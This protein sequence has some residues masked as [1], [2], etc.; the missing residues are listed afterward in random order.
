M[1][2]DGRKRC[3][4]AGAKNLSDWQNRRSEVARERTALAQ[5]FRAELLRQL[6]PQINATTRALAESAVTSYVA[7][8]ITQSRFTQGRVN[9]DAMDILLRTQSQL[10]RTLKLLG[11][12]FPVHTHD[13]SDAPPPGAT[14][15]ERRAWSRRYVDARLAEG[16][17]A[18]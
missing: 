9:T 16:R 2:N 11:I 1:S 17:D 5:E 13:D 3:G 8:G 18:Q 14:D 15:E 10:N 12:R 4:R 6:G 7:I